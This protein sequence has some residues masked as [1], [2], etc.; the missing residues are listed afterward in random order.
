[1][2]HTPAF[3]K[4][5]G[6]RVEP[7]GFPHE[8]LQSCTRESDAAFSFCCHHQGWLLTSSR[9]SCREGAAC[10]ADFD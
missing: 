2:G 7:Q 10:S 9:A 1:M 3:S 8:Q 6:N 4:W 5:A